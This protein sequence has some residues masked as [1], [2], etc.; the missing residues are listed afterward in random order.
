MCNA[1]LQ[2]GSLPVTQKQTIVHPRLKKPT[3]DADDP[4][5]SGQFLILA[6]SQSWLNEWLHLDLCYIL[7]IIN[8]FQPVSLSAYRQFH[9]TETA[10]CIVH[11]DLVRAIV[12]GQVTTLVMLDL[13]AA[14]DTVDHEVLLF[15]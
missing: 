11:N 8:S 5:S 12:R 1:S 4:R 10:V 14:F 9:S 15:F 3:L 6:S 7:K 13:S 2:S